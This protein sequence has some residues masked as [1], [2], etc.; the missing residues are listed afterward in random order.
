MDTRT[1]T[2]S[3]NNLLKQTGIVLQNDFPAGKY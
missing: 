1:Q 3:T 2:A